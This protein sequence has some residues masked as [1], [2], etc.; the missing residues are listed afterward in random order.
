MKINSI[1]IGGFK[2]IKSKA[3][4]PVAPITLF[5]GANSTGKSTVLHSILYLFETLVN[6]N[7][8][9]EYSTLLGE[10]VYLGGFSNL[11]HGKDLKN[12]ITIGAT[13]DVS[14]NIGTTEDYL[15]DAEEWL[16]ENY[17]DELPTIEPKIYSFE[18]EVAWDSF[19]KRAFIRKFK[20]TIDNN[21]TCV[22]EKKAGTRGA[23]ISEF[24][25][26]NHDQLLGHGFEELAQLMKSDWQAVPL[27]NLDHALPDIQKRIDLSNAPWNWSDLFADHPL[28]MITYCES[29]ISQSCIASLKL[30][31]TKLKDLIHIGPLR[32]VPDRTFVANN[33]ASNER[34]YDGTAAWELFSNSTTQLQDNINR[35]YGEAYGFNTSYTFLP[36]VEGEQ[37]NIK[38]S[39][40]LKNQH[41][42]ISHYLNEVGVGVSQ[43][44]PIIASA[45]L[46][47]PSIVS[48]EQPELHIHPRWQLILADLF[49][50]RINS[51]REKMFFIET[52]SEHL[53][54]RLLKRRR[55][56]AEAVLDDSRFSCKKSDIQIIFCEQENARTKLLPIS[57]TDE[58]EFDAVWPKGFFTERRE[59]LF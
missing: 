36:L 7:C 58:G 32:V 47:E 52:H 25:T 14:E 42:G 1:T 13:I 40:I 35:W 20:S 16:V 46:E 44:F 4:L 53:M 29:L 9:P 2:G 56:T 34:W 39:V 26:S 24:T 33:I 22:I 49:L 23:F 55:Q 3:E 11:V 50:E 54:L 12:S 5:F 19:E 57:T 43:V 28:S 8:D 31:S 38:R 41:S 30:L 17:L 27:S 45:L 15:S 10:K 48:C 51:G 18:F 6:R 21:F 37:T 59:E